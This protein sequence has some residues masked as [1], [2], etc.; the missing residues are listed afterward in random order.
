MP[1]CNKCTTNELPFSAE[2]SLENKGYDSVGFDV[3]EHFADVGKSSPIEKYGTPLAEADKG[4]P[5]GRNK[6][7]DR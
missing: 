2:R 4:Y 6:D 7:I 3:I 1:T 5:V